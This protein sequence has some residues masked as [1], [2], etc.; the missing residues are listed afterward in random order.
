MMLPVMAI[1]VGVLIILARL[2]LLIWPIKVREAIGRALAVRQAVSAAGLALAGLAALIIYAAAT[3]RFPLEIVL[4]IVGIITALA[5]IVF[6]IAPE[7]PRQIWLALVIRRP[8]NLVRA[9]AGLGIAVGIFLLALGLTWMEEGQRPRLPRPGEERVDARPRGTGEGAA[10]FAAETP[11]EA[12]EPTLD[13]RLR[14]LQLSVDRNWDG[15][16]KL[17]DELHEVERGVEDLRA[18]RGLPK[19][20]LQVPDRPRTS[21]P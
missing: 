18:G 1:V 12:K 16:R 15:I 13:E 7:L 14:E 20:P 5:G 2:P 6:V 9:L 11:G 3:E 21:E 4:W 19:T 10:L 8:P 17:Q